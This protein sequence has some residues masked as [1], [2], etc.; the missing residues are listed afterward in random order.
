L[1]A[2]KSVIDRV[3][4]P[5][6][7]LSECRLDRALS[8]SVEI[9]EGPRAN[10]QFPVRVSESLGVCLKSGPSHHVTV[11]GR[12][13]I[14]PEDAISVRPP[15]CIWSVTSTGPVG[16]LSLDLGPS[17]L[18]SGL[19]RG[20]GMRFAAANVLPDLRALGRLLRSGEPALLLADLIADLI[21]AL[22]R[23]NLISADELG[24]SAPVGISSRV[25]EALESAIDDPPPLAVLADDNG[26]SRFALL[27]QFKKDFGVTPHAFTLGLRVDRARQRLARGADL[28]EVAL[29]LGFADQPH[30]TRVFRRQVGLAP[31][32]YARRV[33]TAI[34]LG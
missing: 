22:G 33:R 4:G 18:P 25:R 6:V 26:I 11:D 17:G 31:G 10:R 32:D 30:F 9:V 7:A 12:D 29:E 23:S 28:A 19:V 2:T 34:A 14:Y 21:L 3:A 16:F 20:G 24:Q 8:G 13:V 1:A 27:R 5:T 15:G